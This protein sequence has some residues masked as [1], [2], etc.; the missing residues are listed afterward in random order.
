MSLRFSVPFTGE[1]EVNGSEMD[2]FNV[3]DCTV[4]PPGDVGRYCWTLT[5]RSPWLGALADQHIP[6]RG[7]LVM[8]L[9]PLLIPPRALA[10]YAR[11]QNRMPIAEDPQGGGEFVVTDLHLGLD[12]GIPLPG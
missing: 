1:A 12:G 2:Y 3:H 5:G 6:P 8:E 7:L 4:V 10:S 11:I 9:P